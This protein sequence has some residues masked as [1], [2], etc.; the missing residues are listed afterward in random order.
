VKGPGTL[1]FGIYPGSRTGA[2]AAAGPP[3]VPGQINAALDD[4]QGRP[5]RPFAVRA[6]QAFADPGGPGDPAAEGDNSKRRASPNSKKRASP[7]APGHLSAEGDNSKKRASSTTP[8]DFDHYLR[9][10]RTLDLVAQFH[11][12]SGDVGGYCAFV[13]DLVDRHGGALST[14]QVAEEP[15]ITDN[16]DL[17]GWYPNVAEAIVSGVA[18]AKARARRRGL[19]GLRVGINTTPLI[20]PA[21]GFLAGLK[22]LGG[23]RFTADLDY[24]GLDFFPDV[25][26]PLAGDRLAA[27]VT[28]LLTG[29]RR[30]VLA[31][32][33]LGRLPLII[34]ESGWPTGPGRPPGR[35]AEV[36]ETVVGVVAGQAAALGIAGYTHFSLRDACTADP[37][38]LSR[39]GLLTDAYEPKPAFGAYR[40]LIAALG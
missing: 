4:L 28:A 13:E 11:S 26:R 29:H 19:A 17:D 5:G 34:T 8:E 38:L 32:A 27:V 22:R 16:P 23:E 20:G 10:G 40:R 36:L 1:R 39:F 15:N 9:R 7:C 3:D 30:D 24:I 12:A 31:P 6:Y 14:L 35:Q 25:F 18:A 37:G 2:Q 33:G 21:A